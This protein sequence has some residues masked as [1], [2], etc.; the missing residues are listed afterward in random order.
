MVSVP[1][2]SLKRVSFSVWQQRGQ[3]EDT[4]SMIDASESPESPI[5]SGSMHRAKNRLL[6]VVVIASAAFISGGMLLGFAGVGMIKLPPRL[7]WQVG[8][9]S[10]YVV[11]KGYVHPSS[12]DFTTGSRDYRDG[13]RRGYAESRGLWQP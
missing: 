1:K 7:A 5:A 4:A 6:I 12:F 11:G 8:Y 13:V 2:V 9:L 10:G 3:F